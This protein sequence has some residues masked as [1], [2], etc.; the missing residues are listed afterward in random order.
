MDRLPRGLRPAWRP[1]ADAL[2]GQQPPDVVGDAMEKAL[3]STLR[4]SGGLEWLQ[5]VN[6][7]LSVC[8]EHRNTE[9][10]IDALA[11]VPRLTATG[12]GAAFVE[13]A[14]AIANGGG[15]APT[16]EGL[17]QHGLRRLIA[18]LCTGV[19]EPDMVPAV[20]D[21]YGSYDSY[22]SRCVETVRAEVIAD[23]VVRHGCN[24]Q[25]RAPRSRI[26]RLGTRGLLHAPI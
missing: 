6:A 17:L 19:I 11:S 26:V 16:L 15:D 13:A 12:V 4:R 8:L 2:R 3:A 18:K 20:F 21:S 14:W 25:V 1:V 10:L 5:D 24:G 9:P 7:A 23:Q 22:V